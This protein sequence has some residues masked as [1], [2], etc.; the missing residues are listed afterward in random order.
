M[1][2][3]VLVR[4]TAQFGGTDIVSATGNLI[5]EN[6]FEGN[7]GLDIDTT[8]P[9]DLPLSFGTLD[10]NSGDGLDAIDGA[11][12]PDRGSN[13]IDRPEISFVGFN[14]DTL[15][16]EGSLLNSINDPQLELY[17]VN[18]TNNNSRLYLGTI[19]VADQT[20]YDPATGNFSVTLVEPVDGWPEELT[21]GLTVAAIVIDGS[22]GD[23]SEFSQEI[24]LTPL[25]FSIL[26]NGTNVTEFSPIDSQDRP[27]SYTIVG[28]ADASQ[29]TITD[30]GQLRFNS[31]PNYEDAMDVASDSTGAVA[32]DNVYEVV[33]SVQGPVSYTHLT[34][35]T[36]YSV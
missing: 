30:D 9:Q 27:L 28:G 36:I 5:S 24:Q 23:T 11:L 32:G 18:N 19:N 31:A 22:T 1:G 26:E 25:S 33:V 13:G 12:D 21:S 8:R 34:L 7:D 10:I 20:T 3:G 15:T 17:L 2:T 4:G 35:P 14:N 16:V 29:F 6:Y